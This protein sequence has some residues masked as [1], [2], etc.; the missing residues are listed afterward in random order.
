[1]RGVAGS[2]LLATLVVSGCGLG[3]GPGAVS[4]S[5]CE[6]VPSGA[7]SEQVQRAAAG[8]SGVQ[9]VDIRCGNG[10]SCTRAGGSGLAEVHLANGQKLTRAWSYVGDAGPP[11][12]VSCVG[13]AQDPCHAALDAEID[14]VA[15]SKHVAAATVTCTV[16]ICTASAGEADIRIVLGD[17]SVIDSHHGWRSASG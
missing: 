12:L 17:G 7:C 15:P 4:G 6:N 1:M 2:I 16:A 11:P 13:I 9:E 14:N 10:V 8:L 5:S 3:L